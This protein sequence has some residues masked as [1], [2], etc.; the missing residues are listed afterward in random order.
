MQITET[1]NQDLRREYKIIIPAN[2]LDKRLTGKIT[3]M[4]RGCI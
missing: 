1:V 4:R 2:D 3:E